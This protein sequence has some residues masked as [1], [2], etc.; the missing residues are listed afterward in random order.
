MLSTILSWVAVGLLL[1]TS[2]GLLISRDW[3]WSLGFL[4]AQY[5]GMFW[6]VALHWPF[7]LASVKLV[8]GWMASATLGVTRLGMSEH[9]TIRES[10]WPQGRLFRLFA[11]AIVVILVIAATPQVETMIPGISRPV[12][13][14]GLLL[15]GMGLLHLGIT[16]E[17]LRIIL[18]LLTVL[19]GFEILYATVETSILL[20]GLL[21][22][23]NLGL[24]LAGAYLMTS[25]PLEDAE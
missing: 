1:V 20:A 10:A 14:G 9:E 8:T 5:L 12:I 16:A 13:A 18:G 23:V 22:I 19:A 2:I 25:A 7:G 17:I 24:A 11:A 4:A 6:L 21:A 15:A 3:R